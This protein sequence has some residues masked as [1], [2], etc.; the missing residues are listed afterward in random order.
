MKTRMVLEFETA[1]DTVTQQEVADALHDL[2]CE[3]LAYVLFDDHQMTE[4]NIKLFT[5]DEAH[6]LQPP[7]ER[8]R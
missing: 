6:E 7:W 3:D 4:V 8:N 1:D 5:E 2:F